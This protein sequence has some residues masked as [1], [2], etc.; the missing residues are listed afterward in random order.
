MSASAP[1][2]TVFSIGYDFHVGNGTTGADNGNV[3]GITNYKDN[4]RNQSFTYDSLNR[5]TSAQN[6]GTEL[7]RHHCSTAQDRV[8][9]QQLRL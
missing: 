5:L 8:L 3:W 2:Q 6:A 1:S 4:T 9:G 7:R